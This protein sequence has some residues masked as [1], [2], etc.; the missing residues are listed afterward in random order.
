M[1][2]AIDTVCIRKMS[3]GLLCRPTDRFSVNVVFT[4]MVTLIVKENR[5]VCDIYNVITCFII[6]QKARRAI[7]KV[8]SQ[9][10]YYMY[11]DYACCDKSVY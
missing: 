11:H 2:K 10:A 7:Q 3:I 8:Y 9:F 1:L 5:N 4:Y 6:A